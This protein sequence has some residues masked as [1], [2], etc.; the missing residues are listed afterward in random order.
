VEVGTDPRGKQ[1]YWI[2]ERPDEN[3]PP[4]DT[5]RGALK[6]GCISLSL[7]TLDRNWRDDPWPHPQLAGFSEA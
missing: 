7:L 4:G 5:D 3:N 1:F 2:A 6:Q